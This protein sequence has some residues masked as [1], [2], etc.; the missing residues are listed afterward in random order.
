MGRTKHGYCFKKSIV[1]YMNKVLVTGGAGFIGSHLVDALH[2]RNADVIVYDNF[3]TGRQEF[4]PQNSSKLQI[5]H[6]DV[7]DLPSVKTAAT[8][9]DFIFHFQA[10]ADV[11][12]GKDNPRVDLEQNTIATWNALEAARTNNVKGFAFASSAA[13][14]GEPEKFPTPEN[15][16]AQQTSL[17]GASKIAGEAMIEAYCEYYGMR[18]F[19]YRFVSWIG[20]RYTHGI[21]FDVLK[22]LQHDPKRLPLFGDGTQKKSYLYVKDGVAGV[23][24]GIDKATAQKNV[25]NLGH[26]YF[27][28]VIE[29]VKVILD[30]M[31]MKDVQLEFAGGKRGWLGDSPLVHLDTSKIKNL[32]W[33][34][35]TSIEEGIR[36]TVR[37]LKANPHLLQ[38]A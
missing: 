2:A 24:L 5:V 22:K 4:L 32:G 17:Y 30:E 18:S 8:G 20:E 3:C 9:C 27:I 21:I 25:F 15:Y 10:N 38:R 23:M 31:G 6:G 7:L 19:S 36:R 13:V 28:T 29:V 11:R 35:Q 12:G 26:N 37:Y 1:I 34:P 16:A 33:Q 14:Y